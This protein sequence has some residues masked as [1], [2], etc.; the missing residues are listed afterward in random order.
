MKQATLEIHSKFTVG[1]IDRRLFGGFLEHLGRAVYGGV[2]EPN[3]SLSDSSGLR[4]DV[5]TALQELNMSCVR[6]PGGNFVSGYHWQDGVGPIDKRKPAL[7]LAWKSLEPNTFGTDEFIALCRKMNWSP[8]FT[9]NLGTGTPEE[10]KNWV[11]YCNATAGPFANLRKENGNEEP[12]KVPLWFLGNE[13]DAP[14]QLGHLPAD[15]YAVKAEQTARM[16]KVI[17]PSIEVVIAGSCLPSMPTYMEWD[18]IV[19]EYAGEVVDYIGFHNYVKN[20]EKG[21][22]D[23]L[24]FSKA[25]D[26]QIQDMESVCRFVQSKFKRTRPVYLCLDEWNVW[27]RNQNKD[28]NWLIGQPLL[29]EEYDFEDALIVAEFLISFLRHADILKIANIAQIVN[30]LAPVMTNKEGIYRQTIFW[31]FEMISK[32]AHGKALQDIFTGPTYL[33]SNGEVDIIDRVV[34]LD[35]NSLSAIIINKDETEIIV[36]RLMLGDLTLKNVLEAQVLE[37]SDTKMKNSFENPDAVTPKSFVAYTIISEKEIE[38]S[39][40]P[41]SLVTISAQIDKG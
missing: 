39:C 21:T 14:W 3:N 10:A 12:F 32:I 29:E 19:L 23:Y 34:V 20:F 9:V 4:K 13:M 25:L 35:G 41:L 30:V 7:D 1:T 31:P 27:Y 40:P 11:E 6:Y 24:S 33:S 16:M 5:L 38:I 8:M 15:A 36:V 18:Q 2:F 26:T 17:D 22:S 28:G 37:S